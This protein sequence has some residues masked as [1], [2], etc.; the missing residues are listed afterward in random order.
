MRLGAVLW[1]AVCVGTILLVVRGGRSVAARAL[2]DPP[3]FRRMAGTSVA[4]AIGEEPEAVGWFRPTSHEHAFGEPADDPIVRRLPR[5]AYLIVSPH[6]VVVADVRQHDG[7]LLVD[8]VYIDVDRTSVRA[9]GTSRS[10]RDLVLRIGA[11][12]ELQLEAVD[13]ESEALVR[14]LLA[15]AA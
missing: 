4:S 5:L 11:R 8:R 2:G 12:R 7:E 10:P 15:G 3:P 14:S 13:D 6:R 1:A 9:S